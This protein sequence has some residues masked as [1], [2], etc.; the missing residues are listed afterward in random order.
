MA[1]KRKQPIT[2]SKA[3]IIDY[4]K[5]SVRKEDVKSYAQLSRIVDS[6][7][8]AILDLS[9]DDNCKVIIKN[10]G[11]FSKVTR[12]GRDFTTPQGEII[13]KENRSNLYFKPS[14]K[15]SNKFNNNLDE[16]I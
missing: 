1:K 10:F 14:K 3:D 5:Q 6:V 11:T 15:I 13:H 9:D 12:L 7:F 2:K 8:D 16:R 4:V